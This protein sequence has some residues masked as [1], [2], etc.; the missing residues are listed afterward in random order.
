MEIEIAAARRADI[1]VKYGLATS[2]TS[3]GMFGDRVKK[4]SGYFNVCE[5]DHAGEVRT[6]YHGVWQL[7]LSISP[8]R[9]VDHGK[10]TR[11]M[12]LVLLLSADDSPSRANLT[13]EA[14]VQNPVPVS[15]HSLGEF[16]RKTTPNSALFEPEC[17]WP[18]PGFVPRN[19]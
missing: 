6:L 4:G 19:A 11:A 17:S 18:A 3:G 12:H 1:S 5:G 15:R 16:P 8:L 9:R 13:V 7:G 2:G 10:R 14:L